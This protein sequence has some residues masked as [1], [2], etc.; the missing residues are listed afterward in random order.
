[1]VAI[2]GTKN[3]NEYIIMNRKVGELLYSRSCTDDFRKRR[4]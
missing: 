4:I 2:Q 1:M 3:M